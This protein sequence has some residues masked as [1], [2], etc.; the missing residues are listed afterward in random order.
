[1]AINIKKSHRGRFTAYKRRTGKT[2]AEAL[3][4]KNPHVRAMANF[5][6]NSR[7]WKHAWGGLLEDPTKT[8]AIT[9]RSRNVLNSLTDRNVNE[10]IIENK[11]FNGPLDS[12]S[13][14]TPEQRQSYIPLDSSISYER[15][16]RPTANTGGWNY[17]DKSRVNLGTDITLGDSILMRNPGK[18]YIKANFPEHYKA[19][20]KLGGK[21]PKYG[22]DV[23]SSILP[24]GY[25]RGIDYDMAGT[26]GD[27]MSGGDIMGAIGQGA[28]TGMQIMQPIIQAIRGMKDLE[29]QDIYGNASSDLRQVDVAK[30]GRLNK[31]FIGAASGRK[32]RYQ[33]RLFNEGIAKQQFDKDVNSRLSNMQEAPTYN[34]VARQGGFIAYKGQTHEGSDGGILVDKLGNP[35]D[36]SNGE[37]IASVEGKGSGKSAGEVTRYNP[38]EGSAYVYSDKLGFAKEAN[39]L[40]KKYKLDKDNSQYKYDP[41][42]KI[43]V[44][45]QFDNLKNAQEFSKESGIPGKSTMP[46]FAKGGSLTADKAGEILK[47]GTVHGHKLT[48]KQRRYMGWVRGGRKEF[49]GLL[50]EFGSGG[51]VR[52]KRGSVFPFLPIPEAPIGAYVG[53]EGGLIPML[54]DGTS[55]K[56]S[57]MLAH[58]YVKNKYG[59][60]VLS[61]QQMEERFTRPGSTNNNLPFGKRLEQSIDNFN[62]RQRHTFGEKFLEPFN[63]FLGNEPTG[64]MTPETNILNNIGSGRNKTYTNDVFD[65][66]YLTAENILQRNREYYNNK[67]NQSNFGLSSRSRVNMITGTPI[68]P[69]TKKIPIVGSTPTLRRL[70]LPEQSVSKVPVSQL[71]SGKNTGLQKSYIP[72]KSTY[73]PE[74]QYNPTLS[75]LGHI[76]S[77]IGQLADYRAM[78]KAKPIPLSLSRMGAERISLAQ[79]RIAAERDAANARAVNTTTARGLGLNAGATMANTTVANTGVNRLLG[80]ERAKSLM[81]EEVTNAQFRQQANAMNAEIGAQEGFYNNELLNEYR[82]RMASVNPLGNLSRTAAS[83]FKDN[84]AYGR[85]YDIAKMLSPDAEIYRPEDQTF[86]KWLMGQGPGARVRDKS[87]YK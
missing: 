83:Y 43:A 74:E 24:G 87:L 49:G 32:G 37:A 21:L 20:Y 30:M 5:A 56:E 51:Y 58:G 14:L 41:L 65:P 80:Q 11:W 3:H 6:R 48:P 59:T 47:D 75:P 16:V 63:A 12:L 53:E 26:G 86:L 71:W 19:I 55:E 34:P 76:A 7:K 77:G 45:K 62:T 42:L 69:S 44:D 79:E 23:G 50:D 17:F 57:W 54:E 22:G 4:S 28:Q 60:W 10:K 64:S 27:G 36:I 29:M 52:K 15:G 13:R 73:T 81:N 8:P 85:G 18:A 72:T 35:V 82:A 33:A 70:G 9:T 67:T 39:K 25:A 2:T 46:I 78:K 40:V 84:A 1:M 38:D 68:R 31:T 61:P 66:N